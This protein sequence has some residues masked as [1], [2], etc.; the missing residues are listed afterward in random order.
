MRKKLRII[1]EYSTRWAFEI[2][3]AYSTRRIP[4][5][6]FKFLM[7]LFTKKFLFKRLDSIII[8]FSFT[9]IKMKGAEAIVKCL[10]GRSFPTRK[11]RDALAYGSLTP[12]NGK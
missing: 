6:E 10:I 5:R 2:A 11:R 9:L 1:F 7:K 4:V 3:G 8:V 12:L